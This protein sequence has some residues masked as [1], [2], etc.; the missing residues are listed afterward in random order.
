MV[1]GF[2]VQRCIYYW[3][4]LSRIRV[5][6]F[7]GNML[8]TLENVHHSKV[9]VVNAEW[10]VLDSS[11]VCHIHKRKNTRQSLGRQYSQKHLLPMFTYWHDH[12]LFLAK[13]TDFNGN[14]IV[15]Y[16]MIQ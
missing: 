4:Y 16:V 9:A 11:R 6:S 1:W 12:A 2:A 7:E 10:V 5:P 8:C 14:N 13:T 15:A 3:W